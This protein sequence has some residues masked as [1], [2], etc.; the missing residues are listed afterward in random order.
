MEICIKI[1]VC[2]SI[3]FG[4]V[5]KNQSKIRAVF[6]KC[7]PNTFNNI[8]FCTIFDYFGSVCGFNLD[9]FGFEHPSI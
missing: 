4:L 8:R 1:C 5:L 2:G 6:T 3:R 7:H 9:R